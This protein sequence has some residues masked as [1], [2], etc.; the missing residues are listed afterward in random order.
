MVDLDT[1][2]GTLAGYGDVVSEEDGRVTL[3]VPKADAARV[4]ARLLADLPVIDLTVEEP[5]IE[6]VIEH[7]FTRETVH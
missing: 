2:S 3:R 1:F 7:V 4:T 5:P 6:D